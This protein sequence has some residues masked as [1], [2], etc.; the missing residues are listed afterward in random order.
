[1]PMRNA[2]VAEFRLAV[3]AVVVLVLAAL[4]Y[5]YLRL[6]VWDTLQHFTE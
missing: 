5:V 6:A 1:M 2:T 4:V 3:G